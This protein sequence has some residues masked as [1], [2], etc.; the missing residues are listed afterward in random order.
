MVIGMIGMTGLR[1]PWHI[2]PFSGHF[3]PSLFYFVIKRT[4]TLFCITYLDMDVNYNADLQ[5]SQQILTCFSSMFHCKAS[6][7]WLKFLVVTARSQK[8]LG[9][10]VYEQMYI[11]QMYMYSSITTHG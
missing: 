9:E 10:S 7:F 4:I 2:Q 6:L 8:V 3:Y 11:V 5:R 1:V